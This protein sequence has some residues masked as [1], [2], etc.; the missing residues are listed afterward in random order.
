[1][2]VLRDKGIADIGRPNPA[3]LGHMA[4]MLT[5]LLEVVRMHFPGVLFDLQQFLH[6]DP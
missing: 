6:I 2:R 4:R 1:M 3:I 5:V